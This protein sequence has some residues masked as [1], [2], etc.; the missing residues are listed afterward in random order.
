MFAGIKKFQNLIK[1]DTE[2]RELAIA[3]AC[4]IISYYIA[5]VCYLIYQIISGLRNTQTLLISFPFLILFVFL[6]VYAFIFREIRNIFNPKFSFLESSEFSN[7]YFTRKV[8]FYYLFSTFPANTLYHLANFP[9]FFQS[10]QKSLTRIICFVDIF[11]CMFS[12]INLAICS[13]A[14]FATF[15]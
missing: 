15:L 10:L 14:F 12:T 3:I 1:N 2:C 7:L 5:L 11:T 8:S 4:R 9:L 13:S 6:S